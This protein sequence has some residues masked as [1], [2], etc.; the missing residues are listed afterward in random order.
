M[1]QAEARLARKLYCLNGLCDAIGVKADLRT[2]AALRMADGDAKFGDAYASDDLYQQE[3]EE[4]ADKL[5]YRA[6]RILKGEA[7]VFTWKRRI[8]LR[9]WALGQRWAQ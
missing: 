9:L 1:K 6:L 7:G 3:Q 8:G 2:R 4:D 5:C